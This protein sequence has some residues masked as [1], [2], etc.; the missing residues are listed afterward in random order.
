MWYYTNHKLSIETIN[1][2]E[3]TDQEIFEELLEEKD[4]WYAFSKLDSMWDDVKWYDIE[5][6][7]LAFSKKYPNKL[8]KLYWEGE[9][10]DDIWEQHF[11]NWRTKKVEAQMILPKIKLDELE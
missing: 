9:E 2:K 10:S 6:K 7:I 3:K 1:T 4:L 5:E 8:F 11:L